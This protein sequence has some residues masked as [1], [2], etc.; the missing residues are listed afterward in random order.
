MKK[1]SKSFAD[2]LKIKTS[3]FEQNDSKKKHLE[4]INKVYVAQPRRQTCKTCETPIGAPDWKSFGVPYSICETCGHLNGHHQ[5]T[6]GFAEYLYGND[7]NG[8]HTNYTEDP[9]AFWQRVQKIHTPKIQFLQEILASEGVPTFDITDLGSGPGHFIAAAELAGIKAHGFEVSAAMVKEGNRHLK[10]L[11]L[12]QISMNEI[13]DLAATTSTTVLTLMGVLEHLNS[14][15]ALIDA[16]NSSRATY[17]YIN[18]PLFSLNAFIEHTF[19]DVMPRQ[20]SGGHTHLYTE[21]S[22]KW[23]AKEKNLEE[24]GTWWFGTDAMDLYRSM[25]VTLQ[26]NGVSEK[27]Q[28][29]FKESFQ[30]LIDDLQH[31]IDVT[32]KCSEVHIVFK[33][34]ENNTNDF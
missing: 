19:P 17:L 11:E 23:L 22:L 21:K 9:Q 16:F 20:L 24:A 12:T 18:V 34:K 8:Y 27:A 7:E 5:D 26:K 32:R 2:I 28:S 15:G 25:L 13:Y 1:Y 31:Q 14:P 6:Q 3:F 30:G 10:E 33:K 29:I 4:E